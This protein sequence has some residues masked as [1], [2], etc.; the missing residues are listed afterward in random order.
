M[1][2][3]TARIGGMEFQ[4]ARTDWCRFPALDAEPFVLLQDLTEVRILR[5][6]DR[7]M[8]IIDH[9]SEPHAFA[10]VETWECL[11]PFEGPPVALFVL[12]DALRLAKPRG[13]GEA[14]AL[15]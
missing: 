12:A 15:P 5:K 13:T 7:T 3:W 10:R 4:L 14:A 8:L 1:A 9:R 2:P 11:G 6:A